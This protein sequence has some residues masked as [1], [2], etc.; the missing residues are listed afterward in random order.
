[1]IVPDEPPVIGVSLND[2]KRSPRQV[3]CQATGEFREELRRGPEGIFTEPEFLDGNKV[4][5]ARTKTSKISSPLAV[6]ASTAADT[7]SGIASETKNGC[8]LRWSTTHLTFM[9]WSKWVANTRI[10]HDL[11]SSV[12][13]YHFDSTQPLGL[14]ELQG[15]RHVI[16]EE[17]VLL[18]FQ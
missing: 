18:D 14:E 10:Q 3:L 12:V 9:V 11:G 8:D 15:K 1:M 13:A 6:N 4:L 7:S 17:M 2:H 5:D 16:D